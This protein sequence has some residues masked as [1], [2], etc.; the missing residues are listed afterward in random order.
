MLFIAQPPRDDR[1]GHIG[2][3]L[4]GAILDLGRCSVDVG[5]WF[6]SW[7]LLAAIFAIAESFDGHGLVAPWSAGAATAALLEWLHVGIGWQWLAFVGISSALTIIVQRWLRPA[8][9]DR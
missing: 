8:R 4:L 1:L 7:L 6:W 9:G 2:L 3:V 5:I